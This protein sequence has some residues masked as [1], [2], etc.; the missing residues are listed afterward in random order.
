MALRELCYQ[1]QSQ[2]TEVE[3]R[4]VVEMVNAWKGTQ[5]RKHQETSSPAMY[6]WIH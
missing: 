6:I 4:H 1:D 2:I 3:M 5:R